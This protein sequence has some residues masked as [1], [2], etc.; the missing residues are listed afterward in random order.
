[1]VINCHFLFYSFS[2]GIKICLQLLIFLLPLGL[3]ALVFTIVI[4]TLVSF[5]L[6][7]LSRPFFASL[8]TKNVLSV[9]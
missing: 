3:L 9:S 8:T 6:F 4:T 7:F 1:M 5:V 2:A